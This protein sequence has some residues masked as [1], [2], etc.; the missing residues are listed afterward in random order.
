MRNHYQGIC[1]PNKIGCP[2]VNYQAAMAPKSGD[3]IISFAHGNPYIE[4]TSQISAYNKPYHKY[5]LQELLK[6][7]PE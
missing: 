6:E 5:N 7:E 1:A 3:F 4:G 2:G